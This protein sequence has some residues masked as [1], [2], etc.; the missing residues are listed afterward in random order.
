MTKRTTAL[1]G[2]I[3]EWLDSLDFKPSQAQVAAKLG[4][5][6]SSVTAWKYGTAYPRPENLAAVARLLR[7]G[8][9]EAKYSELLAATI[10]DQGYVPMPEEGGGAHADS[11]A[12]NTTPQPDGAQESGKVVRLPLHDDEVPGPNLSQPHAARD[13][14]QL[15]EGHKEREAADKRGEES[16][17]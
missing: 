9:P 6:K 1:W 10:R 12:P 17:D 11:A 13:T 16:Q 3:Q 2:L 7:P 14:G 4:I 5:G 8:N 15:S